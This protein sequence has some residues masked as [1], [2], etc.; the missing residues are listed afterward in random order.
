MALDAHLRGKLTKYQHSELCR[1]DAARALHQY[2]NLVPELQKFTHNDG[3]EVDLLAMNGTLPVPIRGV[4]YN[5]PVC[6]W[7]QENHPYVPPLVF[8][9]PTS[10]MAIKSSQHVDTNGKVYHPFLHEWNYPRSD[11]AALLQI[12][13][14]VFAAQPPVYAKSTPTPPQPTNYNRPQQPGYPPQYGGY[15]P[16]QA[17]YPVGGPARMPMPTPMPMP[18]NSPGGTSGSRPPYPP[19]STPGGA[20][21]GPSNPPYPVTSQSTYPPSTQPSYPGPASIPSSTRP[22]NS[23]TKETVLATSNSLNEDDIKASL[24]YAVEDKIKRST[25]ALFEQA[26]IELDELNR[27]QQELKQGSEKLQDIL[28]KLEREQADVDNDIKLLTQKNEEISDVVT[29]LEAN[30]DKLEIDE[31]VVT[32][33]PLY[34]Q[35]LILFAEENA[36]ED[37][38]YYLSE[39]LRKEAIDLEVFLKNIRTLS[40]KQFMLR[41]L[42][43]KA[44]KTAGLTEVAG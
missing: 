19:Y 33:A 38:I 5:I 27:T 31:A 17:P 10:T 16:N 23:V 4:T 11:L 34:N 41:A 12:L 9:K 35:I 25:R 20:G 36:V 14:G 22:T 7:L 3:R 15:P 6:V 21:M 37:T 18:G 26:Q 28:Q 2:P 24:R 30:S 42:L 29:K 39:S 32:T 8:V 44:R 40:R 13:C 1:K 43:Y